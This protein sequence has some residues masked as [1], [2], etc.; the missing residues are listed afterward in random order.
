M[1]NAGL[2]LTRTEVTWQ[3]SLLWW[4]CCSLLQEEG[5]S[6]LLLQLLC[7]AECCREAREMV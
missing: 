7:Q 5:E 6:I 3:C 2:L 4:W 1:E